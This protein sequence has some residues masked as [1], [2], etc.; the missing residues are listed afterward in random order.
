M[1]TMEFVGKVALITGVGSGFGAATAQLLAQQGC[2]IV[3]VDRNEES[4]NAI[5]ASLPHHDS[6]HYKILQDLRDAN[7][8]KTVVERAINKTAHL[9]IV[10]NSAGVCRFNKLNTISIDEWDE[11]FEV[12]VRALF[13]INVASAE[14]MERGGVII[15][16]GSNAGRKGRAVSAHYAAAKAAVHNFTQSMALAYGK[17]NIRINTVSPGPI[18]TNM[19][20]GLYKELTPIAGKT[21][22][23]LEQMW[24]ELTPLGRLGKAEDVANLIVFLASEKGNF[25]TGQDINVCGGFML[26]S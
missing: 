10:V 15:N 7:G 14:A 3:G 8:A 9:D 5:I 19:W 13:Q 23:E 1:N 22:K 24:T 16:L 25:I 26:N 11:I 6:K 12:D 17:K 2:S 18:M 20:E 4:L 21:S